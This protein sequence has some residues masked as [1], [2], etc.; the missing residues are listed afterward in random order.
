MACMR[1]HLSD[2]Y[3]LDSWPGSRWKPDPSCI[4]ISGS[5]G[6]SRTLNDGLTRAGVVMHE[7]MRGLTR[8][9]WKRTG[10]DECPGPYHVSEQSG[11]YKKSPRPCAGISAGPSAAS[12]EAARKRKTHGTD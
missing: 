11:E 5:R 9:G 4:T 7:G 6:C 10:G 12:P 2:R 1:M 8:G 3:R